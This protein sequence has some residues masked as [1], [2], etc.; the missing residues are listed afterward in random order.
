MTVDHSEVWNLKKR[1]LKMIPTDHGRLSINDLEQ[2][3]FHKDEKIFDGL[4]SF[5]KAG[6]ETSSI[7]NE[8]YHL[9][10]GSFGS[11]HRELIE[12]YLSNIA[13]KFPGFIY[14]VLE[15]L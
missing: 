8:A 7:A 14:D 9:L 10:H 3:C 2:K 11:E 6:L 4:N 12:E 1:L 15:R 13:D 5:C